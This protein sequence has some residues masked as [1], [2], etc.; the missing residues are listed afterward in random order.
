[1]SHDLFLLM[2]ENPFGTFI[3]ILAVLWAFE[4]MVVAL[5][6]R[7]KPA[8]ECTCCDEDAD[9]DVVAMGG[10]TEEDED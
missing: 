2:R 3:I 4:R 10:Q 5:I 6:N 7:N 8:C 1:M 9:D